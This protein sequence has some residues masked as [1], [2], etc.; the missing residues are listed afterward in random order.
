[1]TAAN[2]FNPMR[3][4]C[5]KSGCF[6]HKRR[7]KI[8]VFSDCFPGKISF[9]DVDAEVEINGYSLRLEWKSHTGDLP[10]GQS[11]MFERKTRY[12]IDTVICVCGDAETMAVSQIGM[13]WQGRWNGW[14]NADLEH[15]K[16]RIEGWATWAGKEPP[17]ASIAGIM[18]C[19]MRQFGMRDVWAFFG[20][21]IERREQALERLMTQRKAA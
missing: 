2:G 18:K 21:E 14:Q 16:Q 5:E 1:M 19:V 11:I 3:Y 8:E 9:G 17:T 15:L 6:N 4:D 7:P 20:H 12:G 13:F 10:R